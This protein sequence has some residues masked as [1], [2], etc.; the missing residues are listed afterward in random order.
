MMIM[1]IEDEA[2]GWM[3]MMMKI[4]TNFEGNEWQWIYNCV[5]EREKDHRFLIWMWNLWCWG[6]PHCLIVRGEWA[7]SWTHKYSACE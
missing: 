5:A 7:C 2:K 4:C 1:V 3:M 6:G